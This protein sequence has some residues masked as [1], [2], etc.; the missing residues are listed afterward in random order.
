MSVL[1]FVKRH[2]RN[3]TNQLEWASE[4]ADRTGN[5]PAEVFDLLKKSG[6]FALLAPEKSAGAGLSFS[7]WV[8]VVRDVS[9]YCPSAGAMVAAFNGL[10]LFP[11]VRF[12]MGKFDDLVKRIASGEITGAFSITERDAGSD[13]SSIKTALIDDQKGWR[14]K[15]YKVFVSGGSIADFIIAFAKHTRNGELTNRI[16][17]VVVPREAFKVVRD[18]EKMGL[19]GTYT[20]EVIIDGWIS[21]DNILF[22]PQ[23]GFKVIADTLD[24]GRVGIAAQAVGI[25]QRALDEAKRYMNE[26]TQ[27][28]QKLREFQGLQW[29]IA[30]MA[31]ELEAA[32]QLTLK[33]AAELAKPGGRPTRYASMAKY[34]AAE[35]A[36]FVVDKAL[37][38]FGGYGY[39]KGAVVERLYRD[40]RVLRI[41][42]GTSEIQKLVVFQEEMKGI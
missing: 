4:E 14:I 17:A 16:S 40:V 19:K 9:Y 23:L 31:T 21:K 37:Q 38:I 27:F 33:A 18:E 3:M 32:W 24:V 22:R 1:K 12:G 39:V 28:N 6:M 42:E 29:Y 26:R 41:Y 15:G 36:N 11:L 20:S 8:E 13:V 10:V 7:E 35:V 2:I 30:D 5:Y 34:K 25:A